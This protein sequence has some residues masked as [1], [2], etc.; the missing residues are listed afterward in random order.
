MSPLHWLHVWTYHL[1]IGK[2]TAECIR[3]EGVGYG[4]LACAVLIIKSLSSS[5]VCRTHC[6]GI[7]TVDIAISSTRVPIRASITTCKSVDIAQ[8][9]TSL[10]GREPQDGIREVMV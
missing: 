7:D 6:Q 8:S 1:I 3:I 2:C 5:L 10:A 9:T 4:N